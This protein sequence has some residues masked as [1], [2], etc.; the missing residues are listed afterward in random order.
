MQHPVIPKLRQLLSLPAIV[1]L[2]V[3]SSGC[4]ERILPASA[5]LPVVTADTFTVLSWNV[6]GLFDQVDNGTEY[7]EY[8]PD[9]FN[10]NADMLRCKLTNIASV[11][12][13]ARAD[14]VVLVEVENDAVAALLQDE[15]RARDQ[16]FSWRATGTQPNRSNTVPVILSRFPIQSVQGFGVPKAGTFHTR[17]ILAAEMLIG[18][19]PF[20]VF[21]VHWPSKMNPEAQRIAAA[22]VLSEQLHLLPRNADYCIAGDFNTDYDEADKIF[23]VSKEPGD[24]TVGMQHILRTV[25]SRPA[26]VSNFVME[27]DLA[28]APDSIFHYDPWLELP[29]EYRFCYKYRGRSSTLDHVLLPAALYDAVGI[30]YVDNSF[31]VFTWSGRLMQ[32]GVPFRWQMQYSKTGKRHLGQGFSDHL[33]IMARFCVKPFTFAK[34]VTDVKISPEA[35]RPFK[36][37]SFETGDDGWVACDQQVTLTRDST[38]AASGRYSLRIEGRS[39]DNITAARVMLAPGA[40]GLGHGT[41]LTFSLMGSGKWALRLR[42]GDGEWSYHFWNNQAVVAGGRPKY[43]SY[44]GRT[45]RR[46]KVPLPASTDRDKPVEVEIRIGK[47]QPARLWIDAVNIGG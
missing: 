10:W 9:P 17:N 47:E 1:L 8:K 42:R 37:L 22:E 20:R 27:A 25:R 6:E 43:I 5:P 44:A 33:P 24:G 41:A 23:T 18:T 7:P 19:I 12:T 38:V 21:A 29:D 40:F 14:I 16:K 46:I 2:A 30:S 32:K 13:A 31:A 34:G 45:W 36:G 15:L 28:A 11:I 35:S 26:R 3:L 4:R 39:D